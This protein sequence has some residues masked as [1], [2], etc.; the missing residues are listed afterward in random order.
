[1]QVAIGPLLAI[2][3]VI[4]FL[5][6]D[7]S[8]SWFAELKSTTLLL[9]CMQ[10]VLPVLMLLA[11]RA[12]GVPHAWQVPVTLVGAASCIT[13]GPSIVMMLGGQGSAAIRLLI[14]STLA[15][16][17]THHLLMRT[18]IILASVVLGAFVLAK[19]LRRY[20]LGQYKAEQREWLDGLAAVFLALIVLGLMAAIHT[21]YDKPSLLLTTLFWA[22]V[23]N[24]AY[25]FLGLVLNHL[26]STNLPIV[27]GVMTGNRAV[28][29]FLTA[30]PASTYQPYLLFIACYQIPMYL[31]PLLGNFI[32]KRY[33]THAS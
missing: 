29:I 3:L 24:F 27:F 21:A 7:D 15:L 17:I 20:L 1:M 31:T 33:R 4:S 6:L 11:M 8:H 10:L 23:V 19:L 26:F 16:P 14:M 22:C 12:L 2:L 13:G 5:Q 30:L 28:A 25:Q 9:L 18:A 32:Y